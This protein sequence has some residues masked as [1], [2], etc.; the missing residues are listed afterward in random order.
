LNLTAAVGGTV[1]KKVLPTG[2]P[3]LKE[4]FCFV[5]RPVRN[6]GNQ[7]DG[8]AAYSDIVIFSMQQVNEDI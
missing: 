4:P 1:Y 2:S 7:L 5:A 6:R 3:V 8:R